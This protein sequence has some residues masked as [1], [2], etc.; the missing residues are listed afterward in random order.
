MSLDPVRLERV[1]A[2][3]AEAA[4]LSD[5]VDD[6]KGMAQAGLYTL[7]LGNVKFNDALGHTIVMTAVPAFT[8]IPVA[9]SRVWSTGTT[10]EVLLLN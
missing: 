7:T 1:T 5:T 6:P 4:T 10:A 2:G 8:R 9:A 3:S